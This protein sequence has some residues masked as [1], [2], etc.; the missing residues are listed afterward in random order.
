M[1]LIFTLLILI[2]IVGPIVFVVMSFTPD[3]IL[4]K[5]AALS[6]QQAVKSRALIKRAKDVADG[7]NPDGAIQATEAE[8]NALIAT[9]ARVVRPL[10]GR[11]EID[12]EGVRMRISAQVPG[13][14][15]LGWVNFD[16][17]AS[18]SA[19]GLEVDY[20]QLGRMSL[21][22]GLT[23]MLLSRGIDVATP[24]KLGTLLLQSIE[25]LQADHGVAVLTLDAGG[26]GGESLLSRVTSQISQATGRPDTAVIKA[27]Y[28]AMASAAAAR[29]LPGGGSVSPWV[30]FTV[31][32]IAETSYENQKAAREDMRAA[33]VALAAHCGG[34][35]K[36]LEAVIGEIHD[37]PASRCDGTKLSGR[38]DLRKH[39]TLSAGFQAIGGSAVSFGLGEVKELVDAGRSGGSGYSF[40]DIAADRAGIFFAELAVL[41]TPDQI[42]ALATKLGKEQ[43]FM[44]SIAGLPS[45]MSE[46]AFQAQF[47][48]VDSPA[49]NDMIADIDSRITALPAYQN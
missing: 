47:G 19:D 6:P 13:M 31:E 46:R 9:G 49:Y 35:L 36:A 38:I 42:S 4:P 26:E 10:L 20:V 14:P 32:R 43:D 16:A 22:P 2:L 21:P 28:D 7:T 44:P 1:R 39:F 8:L 23:I 29:A 40:D 37:G 17:K 45:R 11:T 41:D 33:I 48:E 5:N 27:H 3:P 15:Q 34:N 30:A 24:D 18:P 12:P 25:G